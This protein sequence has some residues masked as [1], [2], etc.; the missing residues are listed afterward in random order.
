V[1]WEDPY[2]PVSEL[3]RV[4]TNPLLAQQA[5]M[6]QNML[7]G[8]NGALGVNPTQ[9][10]QAAPLPTPT[11]APAQLAQQAAAATQQATNQNTAPIQ[12]I[13]WSS[14][15]PD[16]FLSWQAEMKKRASRKATV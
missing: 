9:S 11:P 3:D 13:D 7:T 10:Q 5:Y 15:S 2:R 14:A 6:L 1:N 12:P 16:D 8:A 4:K